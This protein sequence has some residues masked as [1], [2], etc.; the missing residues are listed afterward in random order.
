MAG[1]T[2]EPMLILAGGISSNSDAGHLP[3]WHS[4]EEWLGG[5]VDEFLGKTEC[6]DRN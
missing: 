6:S 5:C 4:P 1:S 2:L 3:K